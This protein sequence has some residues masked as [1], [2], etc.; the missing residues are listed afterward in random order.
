MKI[1][2]L[3]ELEHNVKIGVKCPYY[4]P[5]IK[6]DCLLELGGQV[7]GFYIKDVTIYSKKLQQLVAIANKEFRS[8]NV[9]KQEMSRGPQGNKK[10]KAKR[11][12]EGKNLVTQ[13]STVLGSRAPKPHMRMPYPS[14]TPVHREPKAKTF[15]KA[16]WGACLEAEQIVKKITPEIYKKQ[17]ELFKEIKDEWKFGTMFTSSISNFNI[18]ASYHRDTA[19]IKD[20][21]NIILTK[22]NNSNGGCLNVPDYNLTFEQADNS[23]LVYP[24]WKNIHGV[25]PIIP[26]AKNGYR[27]SLIFYPLKAFQGI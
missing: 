13:Y 1:I 19:N 11:Q 22:R 26:T 24:A 15:I 27:N 10:D 23:M 4:E 17:Q 16:M 7:I 8:D 14:I 3:S 6:E 9:P 25:T 18:A 12:M 21:V 2:K 5:N 20:T